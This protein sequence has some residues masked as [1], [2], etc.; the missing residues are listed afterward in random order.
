M[1]ESLPL[2]GGRCMRELVLFVSFRLKPDEA[3]LRMKMISPTAMMIIIVMTAKPRP[4]NER[5]SDILAD[6]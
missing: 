2:T 6:E 4:K 1:S 3:F 5:I